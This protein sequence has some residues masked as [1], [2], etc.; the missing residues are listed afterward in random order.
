[1]LSKSHETIPLRSITS[2]RKFQCDFDDNLSATHVFIK[3]ILEAVDSVLTTPLP[4]SPHRAVQGV[5]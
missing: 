5:G 1:M 2:K 3:Q 4:R